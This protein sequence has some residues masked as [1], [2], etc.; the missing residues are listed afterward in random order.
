MYSSQ[1]K[2][3]NYT[4]C[5]KI[6]ASIVAPYR[7]YLCQWKRAYIFGTKELGLK[8]YEGCMK[9]RI[10]VV[11]FIDNDTT[12]VGQKIRGIEICN[13]D[14]IDT[15]EEGEI[16]I[17]ATLSYWSEIQVQ[18]EQRGIE[19][20]I[21]YPILS[22]YSSCFAVADTC[23]QN[24]VENL[25]INREVY[26]ELFEK[27]ADETSRLVLDDILNFRMSFNINYLRHAYSLST[28]GQV[29]YFDTEIIH[30]TEREVFVDAGAYK[31]ETTEAFIY[32]VKGNFNK[33]YVFEPDS[34][35]MD[36]CRNTLKQHPNVVFYEAGTGNKEGTYQFTLTGGLGGK[37]CAQ[38]KTTVKIYTLDK[39]IKEPITFI[40]MDVEGYEI[41][42]IQGSV[43]KIIESQP[44]L[45]I[46]AYHK[47]TDLLD[48]VELVKS[49]VPTYKVYLRH[50]T[51][52]YFDTDLYFVKEEWE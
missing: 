30:F 11:R 50:Y 32:Q 1:I 44:K 42:T 12:K 18:L 14:E 4:T 7:E 6:V 20:Y 52:T 8:A 26:I 51:Q 19:Q 49:I 21:P 29:Q 31:G 45:A 41:E 2:L 13:L 3:T 16:I 48:I 5:E 24:L 15:L 27:M 37:F 23:F 40:K 25:W 22:L 10:E 36:G 34:Q 38:G 17:I 43:N 33:I 35:L 28:Q 39:Y 47:A 46:S 9:Q